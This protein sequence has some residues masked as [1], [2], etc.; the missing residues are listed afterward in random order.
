MRF[1]TK[2]AILALPMALAACTETQFLDTLG[3]GKVT[4][5]ETTVKPN[6]QLTMPPDLS[7]RAPAAGDAQTP[8]A[9]P[10]A[11]AQAPVQQAAATPADPAAPSPTNPVVP[12]TNLTAQQQLDA[13]YVKYGISK[14]KP[15]GTAKTFEEL[16]EE[17][18]QAV[19][20]EKKKQNPNYGTIWNLR[21]FLGI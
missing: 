7:L 11:P 5:D 13:L 20:A 15:D 19:L 17:L 8:V 10:A 9:A 4:P 21:E 12:G 1:I 6:P 14:T 3:A 2:F 18:R 16:Q